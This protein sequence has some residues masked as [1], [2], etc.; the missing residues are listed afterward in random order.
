M[1]IRLWDGEARLA[2]IAN[3]YRPGRA[4][5]VELPGEV[6]VEARL[7]DVPFDRIRIGMPVELTQVPLDP[8]APE[9]VM[10]PAFR[11][12]EMQP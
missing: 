6:I 9:S 11:P 7:T 12:V 10:I 8:D 2:N 1:T 4:T 3:D 5:Y